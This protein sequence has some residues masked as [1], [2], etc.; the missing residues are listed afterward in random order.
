MFLEK[1]TKE[2]NI[3]EKMIKDF[4]EA[5]GEEKTHNY[6]RIVKMIKEKKFQNLGK[7][8]KTKER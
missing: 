2:K 8:K 4:S 1:E 7:E 6:M 3:E 5:Y